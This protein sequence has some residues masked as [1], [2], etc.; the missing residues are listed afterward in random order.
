[1][2][3]KIS[4]DVIN[5]KIVSLTNGEYRLVGEYSGAHSKISIEHTLCGNVQTV[6]LDH[7]VRGTRCQNCKD[8][9][10]KSHVEFEIE[11]K[12]IVGNEYVF[13]DKYVTAFIKIRI[14]HNICGYVYS[15]RPANFLSGKRCPNC[16]R[17]IKLTTSDFKNYIYEVVGEEYSVLGDYKNNNTRIKIKHNV[18]GNVLNMFPSSFKAGNRCMHCSGAG[19]PR[20]DTKTLR[21]YVLNN[22]DKEY[23]ITDKFQYANMKSHLE[24]IHI[25]CG[26]LYTTQ[27]QNFISGNRCPVCFG[28]NKK[29]T[30]WFKEKVFLLVGNDY[31]VIGSYENYATK[32]E[33]KHNECNHRYNVT[34]ADF[35]GT[36][37]RSGRR[38]PACFRKDKKTVQEFKSELLD[39]VGQDY[40]LVGEYVGANAKLEI[41][42]TLCGESYFP[43]PANILSGKS[44]CPCESENR[45]ESKVKEFLD[46][47]A[48]NFHKQYSHPDC[49]YRLPLRFDFAI[50]NDRNQLQ[51]LIEYD[52][53]QHHEPIEYF[54]GEKAFKLQ[55][56][57]DKIKDDYCKA[58]NIPLIR[59]PYW[60]FKNIDSIL[61]ERL[62]E[63]GV[64]SP[65]L[66]EV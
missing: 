25:K 5:E 53:K 23:D 31:S 66:V 7:F 40:I 9:N 44:R 55:Q 46:L 22:T 37:N 38:C 10:R 21:E 6:R 19:L 18:C 17:N 63:L 16:A 1:M 56:K 39:K 26:S 35:I 13:L 32:I 42:H 2:A 33:V 62:T 14:K 27:V 41:K 15:V 58:N 3:N 24:F 50:Y 11:V 54:G 20:F 12:S 29:D 34:P 30:N 36:K 8:S 52:G 51:C 59:I 48:L 57:K 64:L 65:A 60:D 4:N 47:H 61:T 43:T 49:K 28:R 45:G